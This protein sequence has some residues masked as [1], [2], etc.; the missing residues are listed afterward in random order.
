MKRYKRHYLETEI[1][2]QQR[3]TEHSREGLAILYYLVIA[4]AL[5]SLSVGVWIV[6]EAK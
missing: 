6:W 5:I 3:K 4:L 1:D 2:F